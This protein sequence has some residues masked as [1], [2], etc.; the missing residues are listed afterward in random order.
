MSYRN[1]NKH[2]LAAEYAKKTIQEGISPNTSSYYLLLGGIYEVDNQFLS[3]IAAYKKGLT[4]SINNTIYY[5]LALLYDLKLNQKKSALTNYRLYL[6]SKPDLVTEKEQI[7]YT[8]SRIG[9]LTIPK[10]DKPSAF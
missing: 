9:A 3:A 4:F 7:D 5:R 10:V 1:L 8:K 6:K 2:K